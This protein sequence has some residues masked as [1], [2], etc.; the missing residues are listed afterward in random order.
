MIYEES[1]DANAQT[2]HEVLAMAFVPR[3]K[4]REVY[5]YDFAFARG[6]IFA[7]LDKPWCV[8]RG[9]GKYE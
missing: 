1:K 9:G 2:E 6:T 7:E 8:G 5:R 3:Q 4:W